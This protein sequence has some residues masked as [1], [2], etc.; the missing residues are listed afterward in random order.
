MAFDEIKLWS[1][2]FSISLILVISVGSTRW[3][4]LL[5]SASTFRLKMLSRTYSHVIALGGWIN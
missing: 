5:F 1:A 3:I 2:V 4:K